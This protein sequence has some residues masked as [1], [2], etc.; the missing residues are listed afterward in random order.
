MVST[1]I[2]YLTLAEAVNLS[3]RI[4]VEDGKTIGAGWYF[5]VFENDK[6]DLPMYGPFASAKA[7]GLAAAELL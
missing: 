7:A 5:Q 6:T 3:D 1:E 4:E 2:S